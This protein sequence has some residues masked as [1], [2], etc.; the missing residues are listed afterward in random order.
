MFK[1]N[2]QEEEHSSKNSNL[3]GIAVDLEEDLV[4]EAVGKEL[5]GSD[6]E[7]QFSHDVSSN[8]NEFFF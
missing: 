2:F 6:Q 3:P 4:K 8:L 1:F 5:V 7:Q